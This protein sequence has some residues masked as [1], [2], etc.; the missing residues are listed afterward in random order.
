MKKLSSLIFTLQVGIVNNIVVSPVD[1]DLI[2][3]TGTENISWISLDCGKTITVISSGKLNLSFICI[4]LGNSESF[5]FIPLRRTGSYQQP[6]IDVALIQQN[7]IVT[8]IKNSSSLRISALHGI[9]QP[10]TYIN[11]PGELSLRLCL[12]KSQK[13]VF[14]L[15]LNLQE[16]V[17][18]P[19]QVG[20]LKPI[21]ITQ[22]ISFK[23]ELQF[24]LIL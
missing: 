1:P 17:I 12:G 4:S 23:Q 7:K 21:Y 13:N 2:I 5:N 9:L 8:H 22:M 15:P 20:I 3:F 24:L 6:G 19:F 14:W 18:N 11:F 10:P 16:K